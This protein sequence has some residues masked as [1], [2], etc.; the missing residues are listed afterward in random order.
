MGDSLLRWAALFAAIATIITAIGLI[1][2]KIINPTIA[3]PL[4][5]AM[6]KQLD[7]EIMEIL[8]SDEIRSAI[9]EAIITHVNEVLKERYQPPPE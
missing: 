3:R 1:W 9:R 2:R 4:T 7:D 8:H 5:K 6:R